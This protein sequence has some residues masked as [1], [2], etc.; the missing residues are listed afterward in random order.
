ML[1]Q[2]DLNPKIV[3]SCVQQI[4]DAWRNPPGTVADVLGKLERNGLTRSVAAMRVAQ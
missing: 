3:W 2:I 4:A 1:D